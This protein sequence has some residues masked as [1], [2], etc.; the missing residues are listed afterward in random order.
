MD[1]RYGV[2]RVGQ[3]RGCVVCVTRGLTTKRLV[4]DHWRKTHEGVIYG[5]N[6]RI[7]E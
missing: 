1:A 3:P 7:R 6:S 4:E 5:Q 2:K